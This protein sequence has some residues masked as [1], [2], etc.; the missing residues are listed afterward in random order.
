MQTTGI[1]RPRPLLIYD[2]DCGFCVYWVRYWSGLTGDRVTYAPYQEVAAQYPEIPLTAFQRAVQYVAPDGKIASGAEAVLLTLSHASGKSFWLTLYRQLPA[3]AAIAEGLYAFV[4]SHRSA[5]YRPSRWLWGR[6]YEAP[7]YDLVSWLFI[8]SIGLIYFAAFVSFGVQALGLIGSHGILPLSGFTDAVRSQLGTGGYWQFPMVFWMG[9]S[10]FAIQAACWAGAA[11]S[12]LLIFNVL[13]RLSL[14]FLYALYL[15]LFYAGQE[16]MGFQWD[17]LLL[18]AGFL[19]LLLSLATK[20]GIWL[21]RWLLFRLMFLSGAVKL[22][23]GDRTWANLSALSYYF[24]TEPLP[25]PLAWYAHHLPHEVLTALTAATLVTELAMPFLIFFP[26]RLRFV[27]A[28]GFL[29]LQLVI[30][31]TGNYAFFNLLTMALCL[32]LFDDTALRK[33]LPVGVTRFVQH[34]VRDIKP[35]KIVSY[36]VG[37]FAL[38]IVFTG[39]AQLH[40]VF[41][42]RISIPAAWLNDEIAPLRIVNTYGLFAVMTTTL[43]EIIVEGSDDGAHWREYGFK[44]KPGD[45][46]QRPRWNF[47]HQPRLDWQMWF[48]ALG[49]ASE[50]PWF[51]MFLQRLLENSPAVTALLGSNPFPDKPPHFVRALLYDYRYSSAQEKEATGAWWVR[52]REGI[53]FPAITL[54]P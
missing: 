30:L 13:P 31:L 16:F 45:V 39:L 47:P 40:A 8:R 2:G 17:L 12:L 5:L 23:S 20:P 21:L 11:L 3:F 27:A 44:Y 46:M 22:L 7:R 36:A 54:A 51:S 33:V 9:Q 49:T 35:R 28:F 6:D 48:A 53:Y 10:D 43:P 19:T 42:G 52:Q 18:E 50:N 37:A 25:T 34:W 38:L 4:A 24:Q 26:R 15:S 29:L 32:V 41:T 14:F 1:S